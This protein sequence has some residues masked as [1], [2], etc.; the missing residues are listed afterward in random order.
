MLPSVYKE[1][2]GFLGHLR[3]LTT[4]LS[5][6]GDSPAASK[7]LPAAKSAPKKLLRTCQREKSGIGKKRGW[8]DAHQGRRQ[9]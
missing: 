8:A 1:Q 4:Y 6:P 5:L 7:A 2:H 9:R 3:R